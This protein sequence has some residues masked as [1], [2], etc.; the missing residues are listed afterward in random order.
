MVELDSRFDV[1]RSQ[2]T[3][4]G[5]FVA[6]VLRTFYDADCSII[7]AGTFRADQTFQ[8][9]MLTVQDI[10]CWYVYRPLRNT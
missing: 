1:I 5:N 2:E 7:A 10:R 9:G 6:D 3:N 4:W 8:A